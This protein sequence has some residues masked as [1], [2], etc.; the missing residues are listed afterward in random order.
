MLLLDAKIIF[1]CRK[2]DHKSCSKKIKHFPILSIRKKKTKKTP[3]AAADTKA[4]LWCS[5]KAFELLKIKHILNIKQK[6]S[7]IKNSD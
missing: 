4:A 2:T 7:R 3:E 1:T 6:I 5:D